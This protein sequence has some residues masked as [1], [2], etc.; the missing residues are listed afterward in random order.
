MSPDESLTALCLL[1]NFMSPESL[2]NFAYI[3]SVL[4][5]LPINFLA[6]FDPITFVPLVKK[7]DKKF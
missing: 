6:N 2:I 3:H 7:G 5:L 4:S 1:L